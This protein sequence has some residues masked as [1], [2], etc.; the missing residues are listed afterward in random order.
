MLDNK[1]IQAMVIA[2]PDHWHKRMA[3]DAMAAGKDVYVEKPMT[4]K[5]EDAAAFESAAAK[6]QRIVQVG[7]QYAEHAGERARDR[8]HQVG[9]ARSRSR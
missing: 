2:V 3:L 9:Q 5:W 6:H 1:D 8:D 4:H 7:S